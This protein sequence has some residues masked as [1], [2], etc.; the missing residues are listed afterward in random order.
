MNNIFIEGIMGTGKSELLNIL[1]TEINGYKV[2]YE[3]ALSP[4]EL[5]WCAYLDNEQYNAICEKYKD[6]VGEI[7]SFTKDEGDKKIIAYTKILTDIEG[8]HR[9]LEQYEIYHGN[10]SFDKFKEIIIK[11]YQ[12]F[13]GSGNI[14]ECSFFQYSIT[15]MILFYEMDEKQIVEFYKEVF[16]VVGNKNFKMVYLKADDIFEV[17]NNVRKKR[18]DNFGN[19]LWF[20]PMVRY[21]ENSPYGIKSEVKGLDILIEFLAKRIEV[22]LKVINDVI[23]DKAYVIEDGNYE[24]GEVIDWCLE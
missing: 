8:F 9:D 3:G 15:T 14:F 16:E 21:I 1:R 7:E 23:G 19:E 22:E 5:I 20:E 18:V 11:R 13:E 4:V 6:I 24:I 17:I 2:Y 10:I 12:N